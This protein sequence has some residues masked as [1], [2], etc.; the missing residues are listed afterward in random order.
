MVTRIPTQR[1]DNAAMAAFLSTLIDTV[2]LPA[3]HATSA[4][5]STR[6][7]RLA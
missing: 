7:L 2:S 6:E 5:L 3:P 1:I 4:P